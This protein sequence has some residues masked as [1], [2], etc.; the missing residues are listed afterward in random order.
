MIIQKKKGKS[1]IG[2]LNKLIYC[3]ACCHVACIDYQ[4]VVE[5]SLLE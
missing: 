2:N 1:M 5:D 3:L 4:S